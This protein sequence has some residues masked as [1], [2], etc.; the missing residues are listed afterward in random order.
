MKRRELMSGFL[1]APLIWPLTNLKAAQDETLRKRRIVVVGAGAFG[2]WTAWQLIRAGAEVTLI[3][4]WGPGHSRSSSGGE[5]RVIRHMYGKALY[6]DLVARSL[7]L[8]RQAERDWT[9]RL[10]DP[11][12]VLFL[13]QSTAREFFE[14]GNGWLSR[15]KIA[16]E[17][18][19]PGAIA[20]RWP[21]FDLS[22]IEQATFE[23][24]TGYLL[25]RRCCEAVAEAVQRHGGRLLR[26]RARPGR[27]DQGRLQSVSLNDGSSIVAD[28]F[29]F[30]CGPWLAE[31]FPELLAPWLITSRQEVYYFGA[32]AGD[33]HHDQTGLPVWADFGE[34][35]WY[36]IP[37]SE[38][39]GFKLANDT[40]GVPIDPERSDRLASGEGIQAARDYLARRFPRLAG[41]PLV[42]SRVCQYTNTPDGHF[43]IDQHPEAGN[44]WLAGGGSGHGFK[45]GPAVGELIA[46][47]VLA[48][49][50]SEPTFALARFI[51]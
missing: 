18:L 11:I 29:V 24:E 6:V 14:V 46:D 30:A 25:A 49:Q 5:T 9:R 37:G 1:A 51:G 27:I 12:G 48:G 31:V 44:L 32:P 13:G 21:A 28:D 41:A 34:Q 4:A 47:S 20:E 40:R 19:E 22:G 26:A 45:H 38:R 23:P 7:A 2:G 43:I 3:D 33:P 15:R 17:L 35:L 39:R 10:F 36:G 8:F 42:E 16:H 50:P